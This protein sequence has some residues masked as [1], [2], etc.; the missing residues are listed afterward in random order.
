MSQENSIK[1]GFIGVKKRSKTLLLKLLFVAL[2]VNFFGFDA[3]AQRRV[4]FINVNSIEDWEEALELGKTNRRLLFVHVCNDM[5][6]ICNTMQQLTYR[7]RELTTYLREQFLPVYVDG[8]SEFGEVFLDRFDISVY[9]VILFITPGERV[10]SRLEG[11]QDRNTIQE[12]GNRANIIYREYPR[13]RQAYVEGGLSPAGFR[14]LI[15]LEVANEGTESARPLF[16]E[17]IDSKPQDK[18]MEVHNLEL[19]STFG[20]APGEVVYTFV[21]HNADA[22]KVREGFNG[23]KYFE[24]SFNHGMTVAISNNNIELLRK[25]ELDIFQWSDQSDSEMR[26]M[27]QEM[28]RTFYLRTENWDMYREQVR[29]M[30]RTSSTNSE[31]V[32]ALE[33]RFIIENFT[34]RAA[35]EIAVEFMEESI[36]SRNTI[37]K[38]L[39]VVQAMVN[40]QR[41][42]PAIERLQTI[43]SA[44]PDPYD[45]P[46]IDQ[47]ISEVRRMKAEHE[48][49]QGGN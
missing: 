25:M 36:R 8:A 45:R 10:T 20:S 41:F 3:E 17:Y 11:F 28:Y 12:A 7:D 2:L 27:I 21:L 48:S 29:S 15:Q 26:Q 13:L 6:Q 14:T 19:I 33:A 42:D 4:R 22:L 24:S 31:T 1:A 16:R 30:A 23:S 9:P 39:F 43:R 40:M 32:Y 44:I 46:Q 38:Q 37:E 47:I 18:W 34:N 35:L 49:Q 5:T